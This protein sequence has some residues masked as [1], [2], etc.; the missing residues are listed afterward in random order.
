VRFEGNDYSVPHVL[1]R[2]TVEVRA[3]LERVRVIANG[4]VVSDHPRS[5]DRGV[6]AEHAAHTEALR[7]SKGEARKHRALD[8]LAQSAPSSQSLFVKLAENGE[9]LGR[10]TQHFVAL[11]DEFGA[12]ALEQAIREALVQDTP[13]RHAV[14]QILEQNR[15]ATGRP[16]A[17]RLDLPDDERVRNVT[18]TPHDMT[19]YDGL[20]DIGKEVDDDATR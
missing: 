17:V 18:V 3:T 13:H 19:S 10:A 14:R 4:E 6:V 1:V 8:R 9:N 5:F 11:L 20:L 2:Q 15:R 7:K 12:M 16:P